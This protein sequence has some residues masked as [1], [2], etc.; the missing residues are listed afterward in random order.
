ML[1]H[2][3]GG[4]YGKLYHIYKLRGLIP[5]FEMLFYN[6]IGAASDLENAFEASIHK[7]AALDLN[8]VTT[9]WLMIMNYNG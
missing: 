2:L 6:L 8:S 9:Y 5:T 4:T 7:M 1:C 3:R